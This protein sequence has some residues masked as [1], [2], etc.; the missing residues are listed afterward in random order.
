MREEGSGQRSR[1]V[2]LKMRKNLGEKTAKGDKE[3]MT[4]ELG[5]LET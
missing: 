5:N 4:G 3:E 2:I 1:A